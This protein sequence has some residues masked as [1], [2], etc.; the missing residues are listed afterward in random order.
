MTT[1]LFHPVPVEPASDEPAAE[2]AARRP[3]L[4]VTLVACGIALAGIGA[5]QLSRPAPVGPTPGLAEALIADHL[6]GPTWYVANTSTIAA[7]AS[8]DTTRAT[9]AVHLLGR[10]EGGFEDLG[11]RYFEVGYRTEPGIVIVFC[12]AAVPGPTI[13]SDVGGRPLATGPLAMAV[14][15][16]L[17]WLLTG[18]AGPYDGHPVTPPPFA[19]VEIVGMSPEENGSVAV[20]VEATD[21]A[22]RTLA[23]DYLLR[24]R[25]TDGMWTV[26]SP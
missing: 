17:E 23:L 5:W 26:S 15:S 12:P 19:S 18:A 25:L 13:T 3:Q 9:V 20:T 7:V 1:T 24:A 4:I 14:S 21:T 2:P 6:A 22:G 11:I 8:G 16:Y 10:I